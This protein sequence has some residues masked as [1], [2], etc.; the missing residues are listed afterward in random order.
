[1]CPPA[2]L[3]VCVVQMLCVRQL[4]TEVLLDVTNR[5]ISDVVHSVFASAKA[6]QARGSKQNSAIR[7]INDRN[8]CS[9]GC[10]ADW[11]GLFIVLCLCEYVQWLC[12]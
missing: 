12:S 6:K 5:E 1:M 9:V 7:C 11:I 10:W 8:D 4:L 2:C 3:L